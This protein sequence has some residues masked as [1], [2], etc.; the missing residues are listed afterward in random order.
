MNW[1]SIFIGAIQGLTEFF[2]ISSSAHLIFLHQFF[3]EKPSNLWFDVLLHGGT[4]LAVLFY[5]LP[6]YYRLF[7]KPIIILNLFL[8]TLPAGILGYFLEERIEN[9]FRLR[10]AIISLL[11]IL[12]GLVFVVIKKKGFRILEDIT[13]WESLLVGCAQALALFPGVSRSG[14]TLLSL[15]LLDFKQEEAVLFSFFL[16]ITTIGGAFLK[17]IY[18][19]TTTWE[20][21]GDGILG[22]FLSSFL[23]GLLACFFLLKTVR[24]KG[25]KPFGYYR[26]AIG[27][28]TLI[29]FSSSF[30]T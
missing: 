2:P 15:L 19:I 21:F 20:T 18:T 4:W 30:R 16:S 6:H 26:I 25:L 3:F 13:P 27:V 12:L 23:F 9:Y 29:F 5:L 28:L 7:R 24:Q 1:Q 8:A 11:L 17:G 10:F 22:G 14:I